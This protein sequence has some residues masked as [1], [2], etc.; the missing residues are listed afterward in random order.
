[1][2]TETQKPAKIILTPEQ[3]KDKQRE[4]MRNYM[5]NRRQTDADFAEK[6]RKKAREIQLKKYHDET[7]QF[8][9]KKLEYNVEY[10]QKLKE[11]YKEARMSL[12]P[13]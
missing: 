6:Q 5:M 11:A 1:M 13:Q 9:A 2:D 12:K 10:Y 4:Y 8:R 3:K 7:G